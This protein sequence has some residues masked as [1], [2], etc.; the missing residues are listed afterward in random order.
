MDKYNSFTIPIK[1]QQITDMTA[2]IIA[3]NKFSCLNLS[4]EKPIIDIQVEGLRQVHPHINIIY[5]GGSDVVRVKE[6]HPSIRVIENTCFK[7]TNENENLRLGLLSN[8]DDTLLFIKGN[9]LVNNMVLNNLV[10]HVDNA[11]IVTPNNNKKI[12][13]TI[14]DQHVTCFAY[15]LQ[16]EWIPIMLLNKAGV[17]DMSKIVFHQSGNKMLH[18]ILNIYID[19]LP[20][21]VLVI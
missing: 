2:I 15:G 6:R 19:K 5:V 7:S 3:D 16:Y 11:T 9:I 12:G 21:K 13:A 1:K 10:Q 4:N 17:I 20:M 8:V 14:V 18:E